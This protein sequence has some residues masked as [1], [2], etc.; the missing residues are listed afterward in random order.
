MRAFN[1]TG[2][3]C[4]VRDQH[5]NQEKP[6]NIGRPLGYAQRFDNIKQLLR[7][8][9]LDLN[10]SRSGKTSHSAVPVISKVG[11]ADLRCALYQA[12]NVATSRTAEF[13]A[14]FKRLLKGR[15]KERGIKTKMRVKVAAKMLVIAWRLMKT[16][17]P[18][19]AGLLVI[20]EP[21]QQRG[22]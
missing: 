9:G 7:L 1:I 6:C 4:C 11:K 19:K 16:M 3:S 22:R 8:A 21:V 12:A 20:D 14:Y 5:G 17:Q 2:P 18:Y 10:A 15:E 13:K